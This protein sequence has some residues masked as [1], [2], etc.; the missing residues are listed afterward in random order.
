MYSWHHFG[1]V[2]DQKRSHL[3]ILCGADHRQDT[4]RRAMPERRCF[5]GGELCPCRTTYEGTRLSVCA[6]RQTVCNWRA[7]FIALLCSSIS[8][9]WR[10]NGA[11]ERDRP[12]ARIPDQQFYETGAP[13]RRADFATAGASAPARGYRSPR[14][15]NTWQFVSRRREA[16]G[17][18]TSAYAADISLLPRGL[19][20]PFC[21]ALNRGHG[22]RQKGVEPL[23]HDG[24]ALAG[25]L[26]EV[27]TIQNF[28]LSPMIADKAG[29]LHR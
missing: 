3:T 21:I 2:T 10:G 12:R 11:P 18:S 7:T 4:R 23:P 19:P 6:W 26:F 24:V 1:A 22:R 8:F 27:G 25:R 14:C 20:S 13:N 5:Q 9:K 17:R 29:G 15:A 16:C 28:N